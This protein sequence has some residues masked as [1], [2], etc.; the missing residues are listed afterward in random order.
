MGVGKGA[1]IGFMFGN[2]P[3][4]ALWFAAISRIGAIAIPLSTMIKGNELVRTVEH[5]D[6]Q[7]LVMQRRLRRHNLVVRL[8]TAFPELASQQAGKINLNAA[9]CLRWVLSSG[10]ALPEAITDIDVLSAIA[11][12]ET[13]IQMENLIQP[14]EQAIEIYTSGSAAAPKGVK[15]AHSPV[16]AGLRYLAN[17]LQRL[18]GSEMPV[19]IPMFWVGRLMMWLM[20]NLVSGVTSICNDKPPI[21]S[22][23]AIAT[24]IT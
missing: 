5:A 15:H 10:E 22:R 1:R 2:G 23:F 13:L 12:I 14:N 11:S 17:M 9:P 18:K 24:I 8:C 19:A 6:L 20:A 4:F 21:D 7:G 16:V 3:D